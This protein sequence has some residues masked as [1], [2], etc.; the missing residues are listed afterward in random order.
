L[1][2]DVVIPELNEFN[3]SRFAR[4]RHVHPEPDLDVLF[5]SPED[6]IIKKMEYFREGRSEKHLRDITG[7]LKT[8]RER[9]DLS[10]IAT[11]AQRLGLD[12]IWGEI[13][14]RIGL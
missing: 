8:T 5:A 4:A 10:Y 7:V 9:I 1:K 12:E 14:K 11:W 2:V 6:A 3:I 13:Q